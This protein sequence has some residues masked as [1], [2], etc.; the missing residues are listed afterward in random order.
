MNNVGLLTAVHARIGKQ[1]T[2]SGNS[3]DTKIGKFKIESDRF[4]V[5][6][7]W[8]KGVVSINGWMLDEKHRKVPGNYRIQVERIED[9]SPAGTKDLQ[10]AL[11]LARI[12]LDGVGK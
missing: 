7:V 3:F 2:Y 1:N 8:D 5:R 10:D 9:K 6:V 11:T 4:Y 12:I